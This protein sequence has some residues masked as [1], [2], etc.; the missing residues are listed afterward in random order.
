MKIAIMTVI[1]TPNYGAV[2]QAYALQQKIESYG[3]S[4]DIINYYNTFQEQ[5]FS[6]MGRPKGM[7]FSYYLCKKV[8]FP[9]RKKQMNTILRFQNNNLHMTK[10]IKESEELEKLS[11]EYD[12]FICGSDQIWNNE[13]INNYNPAYFLSFAGERRK[14]AY[15]PSF[16]KEYESLSQTDIDFYKKW[17]PNIDYLSV[18][19]E[20]GIEIVERIIESTPQVVCDPVFLIGRQKWEKVC[21]I[22]KPENK[23][24]IFIFLLG[25]T[26]N[27]EMNKKIVR[28]AKTVAK[29]RG[30]QVKLLVMGLTSLLFH[31]IKTPTVESWLALIRDSEIV[32]TNSFH[33]AVFSIIFKKVFYSCIDDNLKAKENTR[34]FNLLHRLGLEDRL[35]K[36]SEKIE[37]D[38][39]KLIYDAEK[40]RQM[41]DVSEKYLKTAL[42]I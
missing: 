12:S 15:A 35:V 31:S 10:C 37:Y 6:F 26:T 2:L 13:N 5:K 1:N 19:E 22:E 14:I 21:E 20:S 8:L 11:E 41:I 42:C 16:A 24:Y 18:R 4:C 27:F 17:L 36:V 9:Y 38:D 23:K 29:K 40:E 33:G 39:D 28:E 34:V 3:I 30:L 7:S 25:N 32:Y